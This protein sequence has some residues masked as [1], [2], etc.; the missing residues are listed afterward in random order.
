[1]AIQNN[2]LKP[3]KTA[4]LS[5]DKTNKGCCLFVC[6][7]ALPWLPVIRHCRMHEAWEVLHGTGKCI[8][9]S[10]MITWLQTSFQVCSCFSLEMGIFF[11]LIL[12]NKT[13]H[14]LNSY[15]SQTEV[16]RPTTNGCNV[17]YIQNK[18]LA[19]KPQAPHHHHVLEMMLRHHALPEPPFRWGVLLIFCS[20]S[21]LKW[22]KEI[23]QHQKRC[24]ISGLWWE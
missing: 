3:V 7:R 11:Y 19:I 1:M 15:S 5:K 14:K 8:S 12:K 4:C 16:K 21:P 9:Y 24:N 20:Q 2:L 13:L 10:H 17:S 6:L 18:L 23:Y 22:F